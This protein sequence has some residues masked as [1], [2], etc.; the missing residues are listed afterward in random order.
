LK[1]EDIQKANVPKY[2]ELCLSIVYMKALDRF[3]E[4]ED[5]FPHYDDKYLPP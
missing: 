3:P 2:D 5:Y 4:L 1:V